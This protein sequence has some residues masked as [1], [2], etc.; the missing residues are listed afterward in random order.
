VDKQDD[1]MTT[2][3]AAARLRRP[4]GTLRQWR[5]N[6]YGPACFRVGGRVVYRRTAVEKFLTD[7][8]A[9]TGLGQ[10]SAVA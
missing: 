5:H 3:E 1:L 7:C 10:P 9:A 6:H 4:V 8:E 2:S